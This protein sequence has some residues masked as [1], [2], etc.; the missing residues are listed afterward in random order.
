MLARFAARRGPSLCAWY[1]LGER[2][3]IRARHAGHHAMER[4]R[5]GTNSLAN[6]NGFPRRI[7]P[8]CNRG[9]R[10]CKRSLLKRRE[11]SKQLKGKSVEKKRTSRVT[12]VSA[13]IGLSA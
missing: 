12:G 3:G 9:N 6:Q 2:L 7:K 10:D 4:R 13:A 1:G 11:G 5:K 8:K